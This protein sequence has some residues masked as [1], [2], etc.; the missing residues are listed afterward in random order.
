MSPLIFSFPDMYAVVGLRSPDA[1]LSKFSSDVVIVTSASLAPSVTERFPSFTPA[2]FDES[3]R[4]SRVSKN[5]LALM[6]ASVPDSGSQLVRQVPRDQ[7]VRKRPLR[8]DDLEP[9]ALERG[10][11][12]VPRVQVLPFARQVVQANEQRFDTRRAGR[13]PRHQLIHRHGR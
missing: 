10:A 8:V 13:R 12:G 2:V 5:S 1:S 3:T 4:D 9:V 11:V 7:R 6:G